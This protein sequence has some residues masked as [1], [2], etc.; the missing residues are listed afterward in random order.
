MVEKIFS[1]RTIEALGWTL[2]HSLWQGA[3]FAIALAVL[4]IFMQR[5]SS[6]SRYLIA[7]MF[8]GLFFISIV[9]TYILSYQHTG[10]KEVVHTF[11]QTQETESDN[12][13]ASVDHKE[14][15]RENAQTHQSFL[16][17]ALDKG[18]AYFY[19]HLP[20]IV[21]C[22][23]LGVLVLSLRFLGSL[24][25]IQRLK[26]HKTR[27]VSDFWLSR[28]RELCKKLNIKQEV[29]IK[30]S[31]LADS[32]MAIGVFKPVI[33]LPVKVLTGLSEKQIEAILAHELAHIKRNDYVV[34]ILQS[35]LEILFFYHPA[36]WW[37]SSTIR[38]ERESSCDDMAVAITGETVDYAKALINIQEKQM[39]PKATPA[40]YFSGNKN[41]FS[42]RIMR[43]VNRP[44]IFADFKEGFITAMVIITGIFT[45]S[46]SAI[47]FPKN[48]PQQKTIQLADSKVNLHT[49][50]RDNNDE[51]V[52]QLIK[53]GA[54]VDQRDEDD[55]TP[56]MWAVKN[57]NYEITEM[58][59]KK[60]ADINA[61]DEDGRS[62]LIEAGDE[63]DTRIIELLIKEGADVNADYND[64]WNALFEAI[65]DEQTES[66]RILLNAGAR[67]EARDEDDRTPLML[68]V[69]RN[70]LE[71]AKMLIER[72]AN[73]KVTNWDGW[74]LLM[75]AADER[76]PEIARLLI[77]KGAD[78]NAQ[79]YNGWN[80]LF[81][82]VKHD[83]LDI[84]KILLENGADVHVMF[85][86]KYTPL[87]KAVEDNNYLMAKLLIEH[88]A[89]VNARGKEVGTT[90]L[91]ESADEDNH[92]IAELLIKHGAEVDAHRLN[93]WTALYEAIDS[94]KSDIVQILLNNGADVNWS[95]YRDIT[96]LMEALEEEKFA[97]IITLIEHGADV[98]AVR[99]N[100]WSVMDIARKTN[101]REII[102]YISSQIEADR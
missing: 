99:E 24:A 14:E 88:G 79:D 17:L 90:V 74:T 52:R 33:L 80:A 81:E 85:N 72:G 82:A 27:Q 55:R 31:Q 16:S 3:C 34:N 57:N 51:L 29:R 97:T 71:L 19:T 47:A 4:L 13:G 1:E 20:L 76:N 91:I 75:H 92:K 98:H 30:N 43:I 11:V 101:E 6:K 32:P 50:V 68:A 37:M 95:G 87:R 62:V 64:G 93:G 83:R 54:F 5:F 96:P 44:T 73:L 58:L 40:V 35:L 15:E 21:T 66:A 23:L 2:L 8:T 41:K 65:N 22:W 28:T 61:R 42:H 59:V 69:I 53:K 60:G 25:Y 36:V 56:L 70:N 49:A 77:E 78:V 48:E 67:L 7:V 84:V 89:D 63:D 100:G 9:T 39:I 45:I 38:S 86:E 12:A 10:Q 18:K 94:K 102:N 46:A 26:H